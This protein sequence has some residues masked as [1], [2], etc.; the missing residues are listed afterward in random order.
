MLKREENPNIFDAVVRAYNSIVISEN[1]L[2]SDCQ[3]VDDA[4]LAEINMLIV[5]NN[6][7]NPPLFLR[8]VERLPNLMSLH[9]MSHSE[10][11]IMREG[12]K[13][14]LP[15]F[16][17]IGSPGTVARMTRDARES[18]WRMYNNNQISAA[19]LEYIYQC[20]NL[21]NLNMNYQRQ[22]TEIDFGKLPKL[23]RFS[24][25]VCPNLNKVTGFGALNIFQGIKWGDK[26]SLDRANF[27]F[28]GSTN[29]RET[30]LFTVLNSFEKRVAS[31]TA[32]NVIFSPAT[33]VRMMNATDN[34]AIKNYSENSPAARDLVGW[35]DADTVGHG[36]VHST[37]QMALA[38]QRIDAIIDT[39]VTPN[40]DHAHQLAQIYDWVAHNIRYDFA[41]I[42][43]EDEALSLGKTSNDRM[44]SG[45]VALFDKTA[46]C[47][48]ISNLF[49][50]ILIDIGHQ[51]D[52][53]LCSAGRDEY[54]TG[55]PFPEMNHQITKVKVQGGGTYYFDPT[56]DIDEV[57]KGDFRFF[58]RTKSEIS[59]THG[60]SMTEYATPDAP[61][62]AAVLSNA[63]CLSRSPLTN[64]QTAEQIADDW[65]EAVMER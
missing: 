60:L 52:P 55:K 5:E 24:M 43:A 38:K 22:I 28:T 4:V 10:E 57:N 18:V 16:D 12:A 62:L 42:H 51:A 65:A 59:A 41:G 58:A 63:G 34:E 50:L 45:L 6:P 2:P 13:I 49:N 35:C 7:N 47:S 56:N 21:K 32:Q 3:E 30:D 11:Q 36:Y 64:Q 40:A 33:Y 8:G 31:E 54:Y 61:S 27:N 23:E 25:Q 29:I 20:K 1:A 14:R 46:V 19:D 9:I 15:A 44:R 26:G 37:Q 53:V 17:P 39:V 48:G